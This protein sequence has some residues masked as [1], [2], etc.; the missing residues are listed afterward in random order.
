MA[1][2][3]NRGA[4]RRRRRRWRQ[5]AHRPHH[6]HNRHHTHTRHTTHHTHHIQTAH[7][8]STK[9]KRC[10]QTELVP[11]NAVAQDGGADESEHDDIESAHKKQRS[12]PTAADEGPGLSSERESDDG[13][14]FQ[15]EAALLDAGAVK[16]VS[17]AACKVTL[18]SLGDDVWG[19]SS[20]G[21]T[22][23]AGTLYAVR[24]GSVRVFE[25]DLVAPCFLEYNLRSRDKVIYEGE[26]HKVG[27]L[28][29]PLK[30]IYG[31]T[32]GPKGRIPD[33]NTDASGATVLLQYAPQDD[34]EAEFL[35]TLAGLRGVVL[36]FLC[37]T[38]G[39]DQILKPVGCAAYLS[40]ATR[41]GSGAELPFKWPRATA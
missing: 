32:L 27:D 41:T 17:S 37:A 40:K 34:S 10:L 8:Q 1:T 15:T 22:M 20:S 3:H 30:G 26:V 5:H 31:K 19:I 9:W 39:S 38:E 21:K 13:E 25:A 18:Y 24:G 14:A 33:K 36:H 11:C 16:I 12:E 23:A 7:E 2:A 29:P 6:A 4:T 28:V 35:V